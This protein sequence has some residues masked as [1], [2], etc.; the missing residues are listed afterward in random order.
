MNDFF[1]NNMRSI[2]TLVLCIVI[3]GAVTLLTGK[4]IPN[5]F[6]ALE[7]G[8]PIMDVDD[9]LEEKELVS[10]SD[11]AINLSAKSFAT[12]NDDAMSYGDFI[13]TFGDKRVQF[14]AACRATPL[15]SSFSVGD[16]LIFDNRSDKVQAVRFID[17]LYALPPYHVRIFKLERQGIFNIDCGSSKNVSEIIVH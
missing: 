3:L 4:K 14:D 1:K 6:T 10:Q 2:V 7:I 5:P 16:T 8:T 15:T 11:I 9:S 17:D 13:Q 12:I